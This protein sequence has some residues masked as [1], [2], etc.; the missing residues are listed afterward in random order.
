[1]EMEK[2]DLNGNLGNRQTGMGGLI[3][4]NTET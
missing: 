4:R 1:M 3:F 2:L